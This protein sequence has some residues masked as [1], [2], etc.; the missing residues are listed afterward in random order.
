VSC[1][2]DGGIGQS[3]TVFGLRRNL[4]V[5]KGLLYGSLVFTVVAFASCAGLMDA[6][7]RS[8]TK[9]WDETLPESE[10]AMVSFLIPSVTS[11][12]GVALEKEFTVMKIPAGNTTF[13]INTEINRGDTYRAYDMEF[14]FPFGAGKFYIADSAFRSY[15]KD[16][17]VIGV[18]IYVWDTIK[19]FAQRD[20]KRTSNHYVAFVPFKNQP[21][22]WKRSFF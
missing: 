6:Y 9:V 7:A 20:M 3:K 16:D 2:S 13:T 22:G 15:D 17:T 10:V 12:N 5:K 4:M 11:Y 18:D 14:A 8:V 1:V 19:D 21:E